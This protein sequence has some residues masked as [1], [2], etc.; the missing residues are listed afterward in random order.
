MIGATVGQYGAVRDFGQPPLL[1]DAI[2]ETA[3]R[4]PDAV[5]VE[6]GDQTLT[7]ARL[8]EL[9]EVLAAR[10]RRLG[11][12]PGRTVAVYAEVSPAMLVTAVAVLQTGAAYV[13][14]DA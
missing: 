13:P 12:G 4:S 1:H 10:L 9:A 3:R 5:A 11:A 7:Y 8:D 14:V 6:H 2:R